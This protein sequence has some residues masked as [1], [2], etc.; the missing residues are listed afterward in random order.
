VKI[1]V[2]RGGKTY[3]A[4]AIAGNAGRNAIQFGTGGLKKGRY[5]VTVTPKGGRGDAGV[6]HG[7]IGPVRVPRGARRAD[8]YRVH[9]LRS[10]LS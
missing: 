5:T 4:K 6:I 7:L 9:P 1:V 2:R 3:R 8:R 10:G